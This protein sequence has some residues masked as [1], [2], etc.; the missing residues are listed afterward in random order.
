LRGGSWDNETV[1]CRMANRNN[2]NPHNDWNNNGFRLCLAC[3]SEQDG[4]PLVNRRLSRMPEIITGSK[5][6]AREALLKRQR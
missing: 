2:N 4:F 1:N 3:S 5:Q 6:G